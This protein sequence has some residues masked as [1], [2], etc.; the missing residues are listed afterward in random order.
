MCITSSAKVPLSHA[1]AALTWLRWAKASCCSRVMPASL[2]IFSALSPMSSP[3]DGSRVAGVVGRRSFGREPGERPHLFAEGPRPARLEE[4]PGEGLARH[5]RH[6]GL[7]VGAADDGDRALPGEHCLRGAGH[8]LEARRAGP[9][10]AE[11]LDVL[12][13]PGAQDDLPGD[14]RRVEA[15][16]DLPVDDELHFGRVEL[17]AS[18]ELPDHEAREIERAHAPVHAGTL[19]ERRPQAADDG[20]ALPLRRRGRVPVGVRVGGGARSAGVLC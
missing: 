11:G 14:V 5:H 7:A 13:H 9:A 18:E 3:V 10:D 1:L 19:R 20:D 17:G 12:G 2:A 4:S 8:R 6:V 16:D 15:R